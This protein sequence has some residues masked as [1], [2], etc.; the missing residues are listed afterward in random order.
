[1]NCSRQ[2]LIGSIHLDKVGY[3]R[4]GFHFCSFYP[5]AEWRQHDVQCGLGSG[6]DS[7]VCVAC[8]IRK[9]NSENSWQ[10]RRSQICLHSDL[11]D[12][13]TTHSLKAAQLKT[14]DTNQDQNGCPRTRVCSL[15]VISQL[16]KQKG[17]KTIIGEK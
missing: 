12:P 14:K 13:W 4:W 5:G 1:M 15:S 3:R 2:N 11:M 8:R 7:V 9:L 6:A 16:I 10:E 17:K